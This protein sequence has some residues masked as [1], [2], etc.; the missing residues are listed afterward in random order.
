MSD[1]PTGLV[2]EGKLLMTD[3][4]A[5]GAYNFIK[6]NVIKGLSIGYQ[7]DPSKVT[8]AGD[9]TRTITEVNLSVLIR[10]VRAA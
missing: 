5:Q 8:Y 2:C 3:P 9:G 10:T 6:N 4:G 1:C 7:V